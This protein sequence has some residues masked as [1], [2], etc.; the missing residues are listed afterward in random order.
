MNENQETQTAQQQGQDMV[1]VFSTE[2]IESILDSIN[3][4]VFTSG[5]EQTPENNTGQE[6]GNIQETQEDYFQEMQ[7]ED[8]PDEI[9]TMENDFNML[10]N[11]IDET[12]SRFSGAEWFDT[13]RSMEI[14]IAGIGGIG[15][16][17]AFLV[18][19]L[20]PEHITLFD[21]DVVEPANM[22]GQLFNSMQI[23]TEKVRA[24]GEIMGSF[25]DY[26]RCNLFAELYAGQR[27]SDI[28]MC[29]FDNMKARKKFFESW[30]NHVKE[31]DEEKRKNCLYVDGRLGMEELQVYSIR[32]D[33]TDLMRRYE[34]EF[35]FDDS[36]A[37][38]VPC[39]MKQT[40]F[41]A[42]MIGSIMTNILVN[43][44]TNINTPIDIRTMPFI[45][46]YDATDMRMQI[47]V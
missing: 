39:S 43:F 3:G 12:T 15:S 29:G 8:E 31:T 41:M 36:E 5:S 34:T 18:S 44:A 24:M 17:L 2:S 13:I 4:N 30:M 40:S 23:G 21:N 14:T 46:L 25:S 32:G 47:T 20:K 6:S 42:A 33:E 22:S 35:L 7:S 28:M 11:E 26:Y 38:N 45:T 16:Y 9:E 37:E 1:S 19:R 10:T 27:V